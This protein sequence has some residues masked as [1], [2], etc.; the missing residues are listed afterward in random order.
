MKNDK[1]L[2][3]FEAIFKI[4]CKCLGVLSFAFDPKSYRQTT[5]TRHRMIILKYFVFKAYDA[6]THDV[7]LT[8]AIET[9]IYSWEDNTLI[10]QFMLEWLE[11]RHI[12]LPTYHNLQTIITLVIRERNRKIRYEFNLL[13][14]QEHRA[15]LDKL[16]EKQTNSGRQEY[17]RS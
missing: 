16:M 7:L 12:E 13:L 9:Q 8:A 10:F 14:G 15:A 1:F 2:V 5:Y 11:W 6:S 3:L 17:I 4:A